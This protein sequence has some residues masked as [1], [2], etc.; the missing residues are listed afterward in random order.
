MKASMKKSS[1]MIVF[2]V[3]PPRRFTQH[4]KKNTGSSIS[5]AGAEYDGL[6]NGQGA[7]VVTTRNIGVL[8]IKKSL[9]FDYYKHYFDRSFNGKKFMFLLFLFLSSDMN[10]FIPSH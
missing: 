2:P 6:G 10:Y 8:K 5:D 4:H 3:F 9:L 7:S 1:C